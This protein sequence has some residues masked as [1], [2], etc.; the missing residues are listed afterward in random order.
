MEEWLLAEDH[1]GEHGSQTPHVEAVIVLLEID[2][3]LRTLEVSGGNSDVVFGT[4]VVELGQAPINK[5]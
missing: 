2:Q 5:T 3:K 4:G 1:G